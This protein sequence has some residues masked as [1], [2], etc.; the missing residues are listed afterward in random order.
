MRHFGRLEDGIGRHS[1]IRLFKP[2]SAASMALRNL[3]MSPTSMPEQ[4]DKP[5]QK[6]RFALRSGRSRWQSRAIRKRIRDLRKAWCSW[7]SVFQGKCALF[8]GF[9]PRLWLSSVP[10]CAGQDVADKAYRVAHRTS[11]LFRRA[12]PQ[13]HVIAGCCA[14][15]GD[16]HETKRVYQTLKLIEHS[17]ASV[18][19]AAI[20]KQNSCHAAAGL[21]QKMCAV[22]QFGIR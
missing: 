7:R 20:T 22:G 14:L 8:E 19:R 1:K 21:I 16:Q 3:V 15:A 2:A 9:R 12:G 4:E 17:L 10:Q 18:V 11:G 6:Q 5:G 13:S